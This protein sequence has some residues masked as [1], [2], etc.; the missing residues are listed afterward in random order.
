MDKSQIQE[1]MEIVGSNDQ[2][3]AIV[4]NLEGDA[5]KI[6]KDAEGHHHYIPISWVSHVDTHVHLNVTGDQA[7]QQ[8]TTE[9]PAGSAS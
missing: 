7:M 6:T 9:A 8:W 5:I 4:D 1:H 2:F 3:F